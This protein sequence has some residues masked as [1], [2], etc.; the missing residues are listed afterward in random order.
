MGQQPVELQILRCFFQSQPARSDFIQ[1]NSLSGGQP[2]LPRPIAVQ[3]QQVSKP[4]HT[5]ATCS[6]TFIRLHGRLN[7]PKASLDSHSQSST[8]FPERAGGSPSSQTVSYRPYVCSL[9]P[10]WVS[11]RVSHK[12]EVREYGVGELHFHRAASETSKYINLSIYIYI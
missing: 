10:T 12:E 1:M 3:S 5:Q 2:C 7:V 8:L 9:Q 6:T 11:L 4:V